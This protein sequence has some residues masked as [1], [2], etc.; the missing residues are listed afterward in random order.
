MPNK[1]FESAEPIPISQ[2]FNQRMRKIR[3]RLS[4]IL[5]DETID[6]D[7]KISQ[8]DDLIVDTQTLVFMEEFENNKN[9]CA[10]AYFLSAEIYYHEMRLYYVAPKNKIEILEAYRSIRECLDFV[11]QNYIELQNLGDKPDY[12]FIASHNSFGI[13]DLAEALKES[14]REAMELITDASVIPTTSPQ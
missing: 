1:F 13:S 2:N 12:E 3:Q 8:L 9:Y 4:S 14:S 7:S 11:S 6:R 5:A 10:S